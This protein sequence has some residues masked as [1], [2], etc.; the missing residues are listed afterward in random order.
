MHLPWL[1]FLFVLVLVAFDQWSKGAVFEFL[2][3]SKMLH[4]APEGY[5]INVNGHRRWVLWDP[6][7]AFML[8]KNPGAAF[9]SFDNVPHLLIWG[10]VLAVGFLS[11]FC[12]KIPKQP[13]FFLAAVTLVLGGALGNLVDNFWT[14]PRIDGHPYGL[15]RDFLDV[16]FVSADD[17][18]GG[19]GWNY[20][21]PTFNVADSCITVGAILWLA[22]SLFVKD[23][24]ATTDEAANASA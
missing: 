8:S 18:Q 5:G 20:H 17:G 19:W 6:H 7:F 14:G 2:D 3:P 1:R 21:F 4:D 9:G 16:W 12:W 10:R 13:W 15:V 11:W 23:P 22:G 24:L